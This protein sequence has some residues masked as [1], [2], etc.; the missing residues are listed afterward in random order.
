MKSLQRGAGIFLVLALLLST[1]MLSAQDDTQVTVVG[2]GIVSPV[3]QS[4]VTASGVPVSLD[5]SISGTNGG[6]EKFCVGAADVT[7]AARTISAAE[8][9]KCTQNNVTY[10][11]LLVGHDIIAFVARPDAAYTPCLTSENLNIVFPPSAQSQITNWQQVSP[12]NPSI[13]LTVFVP[14]TSS[15]TFTVLD[16]LIPGDGIR[17]DATA[18]ADEAAIIAAVSADPGAIGVVSLKAA[19][20]ADG[21]LKIL[22]LNTNDAAGC[23]TPL[24]ENVD[25]GAY[26]AADDFFVYVSKAS[27]DKA[28]LKDAL[29]F[30]S[31]D[32]AAGVIDSLGFS[33]PSATTYAKNQASLEGTG[34]T[35]PFSSATTSFQI[36][37]DVAGPVAAAGATSGREYLSNAGAAFQATYQQVT[38]EVKTEGQPA[39]IR[40]L[41]NGEI[42]IAI[43][44]ADLTA[45]QSQNCDANNIKTLPIDLGKQAVVLVANA[46]STQLACLTTDQLKKTFEAASAKTVTNWNQVDSTFPDQ[47]MTLFTPNLG[48]SYTDLLLIKAANTDIPARDDTQLNDDPLYRAAATANVEGGLTYMSWTDYQQ[49]LAN[50]QERIQLVGVNGGNGCVTPSAE[51]ISD[52][53]YPLTR[54][55]KL[56][57]NT[58]SLTEVPVQSFLW[59]LA[60]DSNYGQLE[61]AGLIGVGFGDFPVLR[62]TL[63]KAY[64]DAQIAA[65][66]ATPEPTSEA[67]PEA[68]PA[69]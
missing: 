27:L 42:D 62:E 68:T 54:S 32:Q 64:L 19:T 11:E 45:E 31:S 58:K 13:P 33:A 36:P 41:C 16:N 59:Y 10:T 8:D 69:S 24:T 1:S 57:V 12:E 15:T 61:N 67:T 3:L 5:V 22:Q 55:A 43:V 66:E 65:A 6:F 23:T 56:L 9:S 60:D 51:T 29:T 50:N 7:T 17:S 34:D 40:R 4:L 26:T 46:A 28:G 47:A 35:R 18:P 2:S 52:G 53:T 44:D 48:D 20:A 21:Q 38:V 25:S 49:V 37:L 63:Q 30:A 14:Q 39:G